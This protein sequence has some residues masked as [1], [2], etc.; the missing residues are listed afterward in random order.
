[1][2]VPVGTGHADHRQVQAAR[3]DEFERAGRAASQSR[4]SSGAWIRAKAHR[5]VVPASPSALP[6]H[7]ARI[8][9]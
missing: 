7:T 4:C 2:V 5:G 9:G 6:R 8:A 1:L 3:A